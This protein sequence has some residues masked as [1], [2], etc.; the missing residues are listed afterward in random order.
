MCKYCEDEEHFKFDIARVSSN[1]DSFVIRDPAADH[2]ERDKKWHARY[3]D[4]A[5]HVSSWSLD[6]STKVGAVA[7]RDGQVLSLSY[8]GFP[9]GIRDSEERLNDRETKYG[10]IVHAEMNVIYNASL[11]GVSLKGATL[12]VSGLPVCSTCTLGVIQAGIS[13][14]V[15]RSRDINRSE[16]WRA[17]W[18]KSSELLREAGVAVVVVD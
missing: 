3:L 16:K 7:F 5:E 12:Y 1:Y 9:R 10:M 15:I 14:V 8:N 2:A 18:D 17:S 4:L 13:R 6:P 11:T